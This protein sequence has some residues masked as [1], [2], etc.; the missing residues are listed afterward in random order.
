MRKLLHTRGEV[1]ARLPRAGIHRVLVCRSVHTLGD[2]LTLTPLLTELAHT[3]PGAEVDIMS[4]CP[5]ADALYGSFSNVRNVYRLPRHIAGHLLA[6]VLTLR[7]M[8]R[9]HYDLVIDPDLQSQSGRLM[10]LIARAT[11]TLGYVS[12]RKSG[13]VSHGVPPPAE[14][15]HKAKTPVYLLR[16]ALGEDP[17]ARAFPQPSLGLTHAE[18]ACGRRT[19]DRLLE[20]LQTDARGLRIAIFANATRNKL[21]AHDWWQAFIASL[22]QTLPDCRIIEILPAFGASMLDDRFP[23][24]YSSDVRKMAALIANLDAYVSADCGVMHLAWASGTPTVGLFSVTDPAEWGPFGSNADALTLGTATPAQLSQQ[25][26]GLLL[27]GRT[28]ANHAARNR[29]QPITPRSPAK[30]SATPR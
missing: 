1:G 9:Q 15:R 7:R 10:A 14:L 29:G 17:F 13:V 12:P 11:H 26:A 4:G 23:C 8:R 22:Q 2:S 24:F 25:T 27:H 6:T 3:Y 21:L 16:T 30:A 20:M 5:I 18:L 28:R 19:R